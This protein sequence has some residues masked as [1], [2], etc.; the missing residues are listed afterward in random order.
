MADEQPTLRQVLDAIRA[1]DQQVRDLAAEQR[2]QALELRGNQ[3]ELKG[4]LA[5][6]RWATNERL[7]QV[8]RRLDTLIDSVA[9][10]RR[11]HEHHWHPETD[12][13]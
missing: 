9:D 13:E 10:L 4:S 2:V 3:A 6:F 1:L 12:T 7:G 5:E 11:D 8:T